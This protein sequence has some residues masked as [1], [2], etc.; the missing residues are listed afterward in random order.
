MVNKWLWHGINEFYSYRNKKALQ[1]AE[2]IK[3]EIVESIE[4]NL[5]DD[6]FI[7]I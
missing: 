3:R 2:A 4:Y 5:Y 6:G 7:L 1:K